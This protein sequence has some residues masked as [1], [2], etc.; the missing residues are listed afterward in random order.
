MNKKRTSRVP[1]P[2]TLGRNATPLVDRDYPHFNKKK[3]VIGLVVTL[4]VLSLIFL[5]LVWQG[6]TIS[7]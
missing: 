1:D 4:I 5:L 3:V 2:A 6:A 7:P